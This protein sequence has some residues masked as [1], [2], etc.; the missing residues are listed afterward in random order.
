MLTVVKFSISQQKIH[1]FACNNLTICDDINEK[2]EAGHVW[3]DI[4]TNIDCI[5]DVL[6]EKERA[7]R[8]DGYFSHIAYGFAMR[9]DWKYANEVKKLFIK[10]GRSGL[11]DRLKRKHRDKRGGGK[12]S[13]AESNGAKPI[14]FNSFLGVF[15]GMMFGGILALVLALVEFLWQ[16]KKIANSEKLLSNISTK[17]QIPIAETTG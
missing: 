3:L 10:Y 1:F 6:N 8:L 2:L 4:D 17:S 13:Q 11:I 16:S 12:R 9:Q 14:S 15:A 7:Y 5:H